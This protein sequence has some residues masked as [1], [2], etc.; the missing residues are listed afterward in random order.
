MARLNTTLDTSEGIAIAFLPFCFYQRV[1][2]IP[3]L[4]YRS[5]LSSPSPSPNTPVPEK[6]QVQGEGIWTGADI[7]QIGQKLFFFVKTGGFLRQLVVICDTF[8]GFLN[9]IDK[10]RRE[11]DGDKRGFCD[12]MVMTVQ[13]RRSGSEVIL[14]SPLSR[15]SSLGC[16]PAHQT[17]GTASP[18]ST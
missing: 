10:L 15:H 1:P 18:A 12:G 8:D 4:C 13:T 5:K 2:L 7:K 14:S 3:V 6:N 11:G 16:D 9:R 17:T